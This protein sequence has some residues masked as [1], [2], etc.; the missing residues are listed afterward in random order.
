MSNVLFL[1][2]INK[3]WL[4]L[5]KIMCDKLLALVKFIENSFRLGGRKDSQTHIT[6]YS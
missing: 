3:M 6:S 4:M 1:S 2:L 5:M